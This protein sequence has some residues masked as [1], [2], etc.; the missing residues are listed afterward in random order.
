M[1]NGIASPLWQSRFPSIIVRKQLLWSYLQALRFSVPLMEH[2]E[3]IKALFAYC[4][5]FVRVSLMRTAIE[6]KKAAL[7]C[8]A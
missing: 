4:Q 2:P 7:I 8:V 5:S 6:N 1:K 3:L